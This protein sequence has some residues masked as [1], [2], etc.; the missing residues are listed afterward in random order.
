MTEKE[1]PTMTEIERLHE[2]L[3]AELPDAFLRLDRPRS[4]AG[5][6]WLDANHHGHTVHVQ[7]S[8]K[9]GFG[10][11]ASQFDEGF[12]EKPEEV[13]A[14]FADVHH[15]V[16]SLLLH[17]QHTSPPEAVFLRE[18]RRKVHATQTEVATRMGV[19][20]AAVSKLERR[21]EITLR[22]LERYVHAIGGEL[23]LRV[24]VGDEVFTLTRQGERSEERP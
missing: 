1:S 15:R 9:R 7:W 4:E 19:A 23:E 5:E 11:T 21:E 17:R 18:L 13:Y 24:R 10:V 16:L 14:T 3:G 12:G 2:A 22:S 8:P 20:Q 6:W